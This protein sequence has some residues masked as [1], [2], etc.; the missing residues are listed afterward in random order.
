MSAARRTKASPDP[1]LRRLPAVE[2]LLETP[3]LTP[4]I[5][6]Y[7][8]PLVTAAAR[9]VLAE[10]RA[11]IKKGLPPASDIPKLIV[12]HL[13]RDWPGFM[14]PVIN[15]TGV[16]LHTNL[17]RAPISV[18]A[19]EAICWLGGAYM[20]LESD[21]AEGGRGQRTGDLRRLICTLTGAEDAVIVNNNAAAV[22]LTLVALGHGGEAIVSRGELV[23]IGGGF[24]VPE[25]MEQSGVSLREVGTTNR[26]TLKD[27]T[28]ALSDRTALI[29]K[30]HRSNFVQKG[31]TGETSLTELAGLATQYQLPLIYDMGSGA[32][33]DT[34]DFGLEPEPT[35]QDALR[36]GADV[37]CFSGDKLLGGPQA[38]IAAGKKEYIAP[39]LEH[40]FL[41]VVRLDKL[42]AA[43]LVAT[44]KSYL[45]GR[46]A[47]EIP[48]W[49]MMALAE[50]KI[51]SRAG[52]VAR[53]LKSNGIAAEVIKGIS[54]AGGGTLPEQGLP[55][56]L[57]SVT[58]HSS[59]ESLARKLR[60]SEP[61]LFARIENN[62]VL[63]DMRTV[64]PEQDA[65]LA[66][67][68]AAALEG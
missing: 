34:A 32:V 49:R 45:D 59:A 68:I 28:K 54:M 6:L 8:R 7:S 47:A 9:S 16:I 64:F 25:I 37:V 3:E 62:A 21:L 39:L 31:F 55:T 44:V 56:W 1:E 58:P 26:T 40:P 52:A 17:G 12:S 2:K 18:K 63:L 13:R 14:S 33:L 22:L 57:V 46:A 10:L 38:G 5:S 20:N 67:L 19:L 42:S 30:V 15:A 41:R 50:T 66:P 43:A 48:V 53:R 23:Q 36:G 51:K 60:L 61:P 29:L 11:G 65:L 27:Y 35:V 24:R 4:Q